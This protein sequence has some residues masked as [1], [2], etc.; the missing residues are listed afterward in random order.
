MPSPRDD[1]AVRGN[2]G[3]MRVDIDVY[4]TLQPGHEVQLYLDGKAILAG[5]ELSYQLDNVERGTHT[6]HVEIVDASGKVLFAGV[7]STFHLQRYAIPTAP[8]QVQPLP[9]PVN[10]PVTPP[11]RP[12]PG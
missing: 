10:P 3:D 12:P 6:L 11:P 1:E 5:R 8:N 4:P 2:V 9:T 7:P